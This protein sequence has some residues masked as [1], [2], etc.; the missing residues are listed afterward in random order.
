MWNE[1]KVST[2]WGWVFCG[3]LPS[4]LLRYFT[5]SHLIYFPKRCRPSWPLEQGVFGLGAYIECL[6]KFRKR[7][8]RT[9]ILRSTECKIL[10][11]DLPSNS[12]CIPTLS[13]LMTCQDSCIQL[14]PQSLKSLKHSFEP[15]KPRILKFPLENCWTWVME[16]SLVM[17]LLLAI[18]ICS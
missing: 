2:C 6:I 12:W 18:V 1:G 5:S 7:E 11:F 13:C 3:F 4:S 17:K 8:R 14:T 9:T 16:W 15:S 10:F